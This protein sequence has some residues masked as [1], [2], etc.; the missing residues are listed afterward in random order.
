MTR[1]D[2]QR[3]LEGRQKGVRSMQNPDRRI[4]GALWRFSVLGPLV[5]SRL[6]HGDRH[7]LF[8]QLAE[9]THIDPDGRPVK[10]SPRTIEAWFYLWKRGGLKALTDEPR[11][12]TGRSKIR[13]EIRER[14]RV[15]KREK[16]RRSIRRLI[17]M[18]E[19]AKEIGKGEISRSSVHRFLQTEGLSTRGVS[20]S[21]V[22]RRP[23]RHREPGECWM[24]DVLHGPRVLAGGRVR[25]S[26]LISFI[27]SATRFVPASEVRLS[28]GAADH[29]AVLKQ[30][31]LKHGCPALLYLDN[32]SAQRSHSLQ[33]ITAEL[34]IQ[35]LHAEA[36]D[37]EAKGAIERW[38]RTWR[39]EVEDEL[40]EEPLLIEELQSRVWSWLSAEYNVREHSSTGRAPLE[41]WLSAAGSLRLVPPGIDLD[42][43]FLHRE[44]RVV[45]KDGTVRFNGRFL[46]V[47]SGLVGK[48]VELRFDPFEPGQLP[49]VFLD[50][51]F[52]CDTIESDPLK[53]AYQKRHRPQAAGPEPGT[54]SSGLD[55]LQLFQQEQLRRAGAPNLPPWELDADERDED[56]DNDTGMEVLHV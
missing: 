34:S 49:R 47:R 26:Y 17:R 51:K 8:C 11:A 28:E 10:L 13:P 14:L 16:P 52:V 48:E 20:A 24:G 21:A 35:L 30:A 7:A 4:Q 44:R 18:L 23:F 32:G 1:C 15:L 54:P 45:R 42:E 2:N 9:R 38:N 43:I 6:E 12:D 55:P 46:E 5:S 50:G 27:D 33:I 31:I 3:R 19:L 39:E 53:N 37:P 56:D 36:Y 41:H 40:P 29:E 22:D 25:K